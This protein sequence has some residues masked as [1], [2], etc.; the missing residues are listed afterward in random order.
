MT[1]EML[2]NTMPETLASDV[3]PYLLE[4]IDSE[5][6]LVLGD[7]PGATPRLCDIVGRLERAELHHGFLIAHVE[8][9]DTTYA[10]ALRSCAHRM[11]VA[12]S[13]RGSVEVLPVPLAKLDLHT[14]QF[15]LATRP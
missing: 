10:Q 1:T 2:V 7:A 8:F 11:G 4:Y 5:R 9:L 6:P 12:L 13:V 3:V 14:L 15:Y